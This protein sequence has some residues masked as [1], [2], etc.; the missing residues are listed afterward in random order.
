MCITTRTSLQ[1][2]TMMIASTKNTFCH[3]HL[4]PLKRTFCAHFTPICFYARNTL[5]FK[6]VWISTSTG[7]AMME[8]KRFTE[9]F[10]Q[11]ALMDMWQL[12]N[13]EQPLS[14]L[15][16]SHDLDRNINDLLPALKRSFQHHYSKHHCDTPGRLQSK[17]PNLEW[18]K[19][20]K[21]DKVSYFIFNYN[22]RFW[23]QNV[24]FRLE[25]FLMSNW[26][27]LW[28]VVTITPEGLA[29]KENV[30]CVHQLSSRV[31]RDSISHFVGPPVGPSV[32]NKVVFKAFYR[33]FDGSEWRREE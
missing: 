24:P 32:R 7:N 20:K 19:T 25:K 16:Q 12:F 1:N 8:P 31:L 6:R 11:L 23:D 18:K 27:Y 22:T 28:K 26:G 14:S 15:I 9:A 5:S 30:Q 10:F 4:P 13:P 29:K 2:S 3:P 33:F 17:H 21:L